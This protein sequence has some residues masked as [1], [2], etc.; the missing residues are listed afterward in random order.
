ML[1]VVIRTKVS[2]VL[3]LI[4]AG[5]SVY[6]WLTIPGQI[7]DGVYI[8]T[9]QGFGGE[10]ELAATFADGNIV[11]IEVLSHSETP[12]VANQAFKKIISAIIEAQSTDVDVVSG[13]TYTSN[14][15]IN[16]VNQIIEVNR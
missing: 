15:V 8:G 11:E 10:V 1:D 6:F 4:L 3:L 5:I 2:I 12:F 7:E 16:A 14:A 13:A 9:A